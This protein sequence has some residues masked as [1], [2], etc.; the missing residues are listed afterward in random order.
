MIDSVESLAVIDHSED[1]A[2]GDIGREITSFEDE[3]E[4]IDEIVSC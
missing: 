2:V 4:Q 1:D 3:I